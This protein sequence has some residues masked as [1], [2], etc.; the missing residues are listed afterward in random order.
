MHIC[1]ISTHIWSTSTIETFTG[2]HNKYIIAKVHLFNQ[3]DKKFGLKM[4]KF[5]PI[6]IF[7]LRT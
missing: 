6:T 2:Y 7:L 1:Y 5:N 4:N 3:C